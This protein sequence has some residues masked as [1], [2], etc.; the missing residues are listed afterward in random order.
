MWN[1]NALFSIRHSLDV[2]W[3]AMGLLLMATAR[4]PQKEALQ[5]CVMTGRKIQCVGRVESLFTPLGIATKHTITAAGKRF[6]DDDEEEMV[7][8]NYALYL[9][10]LRSSCVIAVEPHRLITWVSRRGL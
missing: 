8:G 6:D 10:F 7:S 4:Q 3:T 9:H 5:N 2:F 1:S